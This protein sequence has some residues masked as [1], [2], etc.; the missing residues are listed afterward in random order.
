MELACLGWGSLVWNP[1]KLPIEQP[2][3]TDGPMLP[4]EFARHSSGDRI[5][6]VLVEG[7]DLIPTL[8]AVMRVP[9][10][11]TARNE[12]AAREGIR[13]QDVDR[14][15]GFWTP[16]SSGGPVSALVGLW[17]SKKGL[18]GV[19]WT[20]LPPRFHH[21]DGKVPSESDVVTFLKSLDGQR[22]RRAEEYVR[23]A[24]RQITTRYRT[25]IERELGWLPHEESR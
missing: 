24:P 13:P 19:V 10:L 18:G 9:D 16:G 21:T 3:Q 20:A 1:R 23:N 12:L 8:W 15:V 5:T 7:R 6:L 22:Q 25:A 4:I 2:W 17:A 11:R 14:H